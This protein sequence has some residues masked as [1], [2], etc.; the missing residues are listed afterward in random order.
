[1]EKQL[2]MNRLLLFLA[3]VFQL[4]DEMPQ[5]QLKLCIKAALTYHKVKHLPTLG[6]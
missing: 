2:F 6:I 5:D 3:I 4:E 1:M